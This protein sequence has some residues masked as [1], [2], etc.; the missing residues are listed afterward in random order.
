MTAIAQPGMRPKASKISEYAIRGIFNYPLV[1]LD[2]LVGSTSLLIYTQLVFGRVRTDGVFYLVNIAVACAFGL[3]LLFAFSLWGKRIRNPV[4]SFFLQM[5]GLLVVMWVYALLPETA[6]AYTSITVY[7]LG[8]A[9]LCAL[10]L[11]SF[12]LFFQVDSDNGFWQFNRCC[13]GAALSSSL[14]A[15]LLFLGACLA[16]Y[17]FRYLFQIQIEKKVFIQVFIFFFGVIDIWYFL[18][19]LP[20]RPEAL[21]SE[22]KYPNGL[23]FIAQYALI[24]LLSFYGLVLY[25]YGLK[26]V[27]K[28]QLP[29]GGLATLVS[30]FSAMGMAAIALVYPLRKQE[31]KRW[32][33]FFKNAFYIALLPLLALLLIA[34]CRRIESYGFTEARYLL[35]VLAVWLVGIAIYFIRKEDGKLIYIPMSLF[36]LICLAA[37][38]PYYNAFSVSKKS[39]LDRLHNLF[40]RGHISVSDSLDDEPVSPDSWARVHSILA[41]LDARGELGAV[42]PYFGQRGEEIVKPGSPYPDRVK[43]AALMALLPR[44]SNSWL[45]KTLCVTPR[46][47]A[48]S[49]FAYL[50]PIDDTDSQNQRL[51]EGLTHSWIDGLSLC[52]RFQSHTM[53]IPLAD[54]LL[55]VNSW[56][57]KGVNQLDSLVFTAADSLYSAELWIESA[58]LKSF[59]RD[60]IAI[61]ALQ[62]YCLLK[63]NDSID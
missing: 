53:K 52:V 40:Q 24:P 42:S 17:F 13:F 8:A 20:V 22:K 36:A 23:K 25:A 3:P 26:I 29:E 43:V 30:V 34:V 35:L 57:F 41:Y 11:C 37:F 16:L 62:G 18:A 45:D 55:R 19:L 38:L 47:V 2:A 15:A 6:E 5:S 14:Y 44:Q 28:W 49:G 46:A 12:I 1:V 4:F 7:R 60:S 33:I 58:Q 9:T 39:Q 21:A 10:L 59:D 54:E 32:V 63:K 56:S 50:I 31:S 61:K 51:D 48:L 27:L